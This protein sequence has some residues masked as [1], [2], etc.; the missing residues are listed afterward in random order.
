[1]F[2]VDGCKISSNASKEWSGTLPDLEN[3]KRKFEHRAK[4]LLERHQ[5]TDRKEEQDRLLKASEKMKKKAKKI[6]AF[7][8]T[9][10]PREGA[11]GNEKQSNVTDN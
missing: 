5:D 7:L 10:R 11:R 1:M 4:E 6:E 9:A 2:A 3:K 8:L